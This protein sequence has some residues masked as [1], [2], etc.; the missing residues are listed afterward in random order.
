MARPPAPRTPAHW[1]LFALAPASVLVLAVLGTLVTPSPSGH[2]THTQLGLPA[3]LSMKWLGLPCP[4]CGV[5]TSVAL[6]AR[7]R[8]LQAL[9]NQP[10]GLLVA[11]ALAI[12]PLWALAQVLR[13][14]DLYLQASRWPSKPAL[15]VLAAVILAS[16]IYKLA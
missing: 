2:G 15:V 1:L 6:A 12:Y 9:E 11:L 4:G 7:G 10:F 14:R 16:W 8:V 3:C 13:G 5:T